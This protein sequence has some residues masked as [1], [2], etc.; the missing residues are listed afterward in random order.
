M[1]DYL[2]E[3]SWHDVDSYLNS[4]AE[5]ID[6]HDFSGV[7]GIPRGGSVLGAWLAHKLY[8]PL[9]NEVIDNCVIVDDICDNGGVIQ[10]ILSRPEVNQG[11][12]CFISVMFVRPESIKFVDHY[13]KEKHDNWLVFP[14]EH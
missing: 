9:L 13:Y 8:L 1:L 3:V 11:K 4:I 7:Y 10:E 2:N 6:S 14:W 12:N 5:T